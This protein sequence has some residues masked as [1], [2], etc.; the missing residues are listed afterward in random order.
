M[1]RK[2]VKKNRA[3]S[4]FVIA[5]LLLC[6]S[7]SISTYNA[8]ANTIPIFVDYC[9]FKKSQNENLLEVYYGF[10]D[11]QLNYYKQGRKFVAELAMQLKF[12]SND[13]LSD[14][15]DWTVYYEKESL[16]TSSQI[17][18]LLVGQKNFVIPKGS[19][20]KFQLSCIDSKDSNNKYCKTFDVENLDFSS[21]D[22]SV[23]DI[24]FAQFFERSDTSSYL[25]Q[26]E[27]LKTKYYVIPNPT[28]E[29]VG[30]EPRLYTYFEYYLASNLISKEVAL[31]YRIFNTLG[32]EVFFSVRKAKVSASSQYDVNGFALD[33]LSSGT[34]FFEDRVV[35][36]EGKILAQSKR[37]K[38]YLFNTEL[39]PE[40]IRKYAESEL[41]QKSGFAALSD[42]ILD[43]E[44]EKCKYIATD[45]EKELYKQLQTVE[46]KRRFLF[47][48]WK[49]RNPDTTLVYN[50]AYDEFM[51]KINYANKFFSVGNKIEGWKTDRGRVLIQYGEPTSREYYPREPN[52]RSYE[53]WFYSEVQGG[54]YFYFVDLY[55]N[56]NYYLVHST[57]MN[58]PYNENWYTDFVTGTN[59][60][61]IQK[62]F[63]NR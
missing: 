33:A 9:V 19:R 30:S 48:F 32:E 62:M 23:S 29:V 13:S 31:E 40:P 26:Q 12:F 58:E 24:Q 20:V 28:L 46:A 56:G 61:R 52:R 63:L 10:I 16:D 2:F 51:Q 60:E 4:N 1:S 54:A 50:K 22:C 15:Y 7:F 45:Y 55:G 39:P 44:F 59:S 17:Q 53:V 49:R 57:A 5:L 34:Y 14:T 25:W 43:V 21:T 11:N 18:N 3:T 6:L 47:Q 27:F 35:S 38:F 8:G 42:S 41:F 36:P 37:K